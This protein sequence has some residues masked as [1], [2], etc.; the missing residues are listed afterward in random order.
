VQGTAQEVVASQSLVAW[1]V[2]GPGLPALAA[3]LRALPGVDQV[4]AFG[5]SLHVAGADAARLDAALAP[6]RAEPGRTWRRIPP[7]L[8]DVFI[9]LMQDRTARERDGARARE[10]A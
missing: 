7:G 8:E 3:R 4:A 5:A 9:H 2:E 10:Q 6:V 1:E